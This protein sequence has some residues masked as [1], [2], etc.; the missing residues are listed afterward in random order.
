M[1]L[2]SYLQI[3][4]SKWYLRIAKGHHDSYL[5][6]TNYLLRTS[7][8]FLAEFSLKCSYLE[9]CAGS[10]LGMRFNNLFSIE[11]QMLEL[12]SSGRV[13][14]KQSFLSYAVWVRPS[15]WLSGLEVRSNVNQYRANALILSVPSIKPAY[16]RSKSFTNYLGKLPRVLR[17]LLEK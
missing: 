1:V 16:P 15:L 14:G 11:M 10:L 6:L 17:R 2:W 9:A 13:E 12:E 5:S 3:I 8:D 7:L 4:L